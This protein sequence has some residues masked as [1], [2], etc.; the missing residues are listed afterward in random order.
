[1]INICDE[2]QY[3][4]TVDLSVGKNSK[5]GKNSTVRDFLGFAIPVPGVLISRLEPIICIKTDASDGYEGEISI[6]SVLLHV[7]CLN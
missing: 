7:W 6:F 3:Q 4:K 2:N 1:L 5:N